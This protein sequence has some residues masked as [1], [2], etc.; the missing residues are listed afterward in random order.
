MPCRYLNLFRVLLQ[1]Y[2]CVFA[3]LVFVLMCS[4]ITVHFPLHNHSKNPQISPKRKPF[5]V[6]ALSRFSLIFSPRLLP[7]PKLTSN[8]S[9]FSS[10]ALFPS[11]NYYLPYLLSL[12]SF[13]CVFNVQRLALVDEESAIAVKEN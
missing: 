11:P 9:I 6:F 2:I 4:F 3:Q 8:S 1:K 13:Q 10:T 12:S 7:L 5:F